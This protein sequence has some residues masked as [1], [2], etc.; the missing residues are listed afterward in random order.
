MDPVSE[1]ALCDNAPT[2]AVQTGFT[3]NVW[4]RTCTCERGN[5]QS[6]DVNYFFYSIFDSFY[7][8]LLHFSIFSLLLHLFPPLLPF[9][10]RHLFIFVF[11]ILIVFILIQFTSSP[12]SCLQ[13]F[14]FLGFC[15]FFFP[16]EKSLC[17]FSI[18]FFF[19][20]TG[21]DRPGFKLGTHWETSMETTFS[22]KTPSLPHGPSA[23]IFTT[24]NDCSHVHHRH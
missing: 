4:S 14:F 17:Y 9:C 18:I 6:K 10:F 11:I 21:S 12:P 1:P 16:A 3:H 5:V 22:G 15:F 13:F 8:F 19:A 23:D 24:Q 20:G 2:S 7:F